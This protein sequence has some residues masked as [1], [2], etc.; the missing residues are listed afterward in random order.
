MIRCTSGRHE[1]QPVP[2]RVRSQTAC[3]LLAP[4]QHRIH[5]LRLR[6]RIAVADLRVVG[7]LLAARGAARSIGERE[8]Q[9]RAPLRQRRA[10]R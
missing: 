6:H 9:L 7:H 2:A 1:P 3:R 10:P 4:P 8:Q 5:D